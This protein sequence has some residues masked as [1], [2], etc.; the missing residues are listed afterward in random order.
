LDIIFGN[1]R[2]I[3]IDKEEKEL[4]KKMVEELV[5][6]QSFKMFTVVLQMT[7]ASQQKFLL[8]S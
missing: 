8:L 1:F 3:L 5:S 2:G 4:L 7:L 6:Q